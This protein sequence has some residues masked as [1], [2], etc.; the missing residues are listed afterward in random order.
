MSAN[1]TAAAR[2]T[3]EEAVGGE[4][5]RAGGLILNGLLYHGAFASVA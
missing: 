4:D 2:I 1:P 3:A 5:S